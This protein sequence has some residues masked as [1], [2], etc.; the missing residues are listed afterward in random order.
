V[1]PIDEAAAEE[2]PYGRYITSEGWFVLNLD[3]A[4]AV[5]NEERGGVT[6][7][8]E[9]REAR[10][11]DFGANVQVIW[12]GEPNC[13]YHAE[14]GQEGFLI[15]SGECILVVEEQER[16][17]RQW[18]YFH[19]PGGT[20]H[21]FVGAGDGP[22]AILMIGARSE[23][24]RIHYPISEVAAKYDASTA[25]E[26]ESPEEAYAD[27]PGDFTPTRVPWPPE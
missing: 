21:V 8:L 11:E 25:K 5:K 26:T 2:T 16:R 27:W 9:S 22:C 3:E 1:T 18:D 20:R 23:D 24:E 6:Y 10:F 17:L 7:P 12:P 4:L 19:C 14:S 15:L 13:Y